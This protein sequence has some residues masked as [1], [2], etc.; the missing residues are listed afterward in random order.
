MAGRETPMDA[1]AGGEPEVRCP[2]CG[3]LRPPGQMGPGQ[4][5]V[6]SVAGQIAAAHP[7]WTAGQPVCEI[8]R[9]EG[10]AAHFAVLL[11]AG[12]IRTRNENEMLAGESTWAERTAGAVAVVVGSWFFASFILLFL[13]IWTALN[14]GW[15]PF[16]PYP[17]IL[18]AVIS[19]ALASLAALYGPFILMNQRYQQKRDRL[20]AQSDYQINLK[21]ELEIRYL[22]EKLDDLLARIE[23]PEPQDTEN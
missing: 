10:E 5:V 22:H 13:L 17:T 12:T 21:A 14:L 7:G 20:R 8:C 15:R 19:A 2:S 16:E 6:P 4:A 1:A 3:Q 18:F 11:S 9:R 23:R